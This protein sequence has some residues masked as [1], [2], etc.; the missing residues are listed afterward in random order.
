MNAPIERDTHIITRIAA[1]IAATITGSSR[2]SPTAVN[3]ESSENTMSMTAICPTTAAKP[4]RKR[5]SAA[6]G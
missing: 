4:P 5:R 1:T 3:T 2:T 6:G